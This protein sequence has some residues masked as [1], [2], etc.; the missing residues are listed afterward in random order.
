MFKR[1]ITV[2]TFI[3]SSR[4]FNN[5]FPKTQSTNYS[6]TQSNADQEGNT[7]SNIHTAAAALDYDVKAERKQ[8]KKDMRGLSD[9]YFVPPQ[10]GVDDEQ[11]IRSM[12]TLEQQRQDGSTSVEEFVSLTTTTLEVKE[13]EQDHSKPH[14]KKR[15]LQPQLAKGS[16]INNTNQDPS[17]DTT[18]DEE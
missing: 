2:R 11:Y 1:T 10:V 18:I 7:Q 13:V 12:E 15:G 4:L 14:H 17:K 5:S 8:L 9:K 3:S 16:L 6:T